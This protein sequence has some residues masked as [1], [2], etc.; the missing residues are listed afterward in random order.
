MVLSHWA[1]K[2]HQ[3]PKM[4]LRGNSAQERWYHKPKGTSCINKAYLCKFYKTLAHR[5]VHS[6]IMNSVNKLTIGRDH[7][8]WADEPS[9]GFLPSIYL[10]AW[11]QIRHWCT[12]KTTTGW[13]PP[14]SFP[15]GVKSSESPAPTAAHKIRSVKL[16]LPLLW[17]GPN[18]LHKQWLAML[19]WRLMQAK[20]HFQYN[21]GCG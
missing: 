16:F 9:A 10:T 19:F 15:R 4:K 17:S 13:Q 1:V 7:T 8:L 18:S 21:P 11:T 6:H 5:G 3:F 14:G 12:Q 2:H 20:D